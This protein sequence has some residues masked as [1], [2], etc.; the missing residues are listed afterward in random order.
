MVE[1]EVGR[2]SSIS[3]ALWLP[4]TTSSAT[5]PTTPSRVRNSLAD[6]VGTGYEVEWHRFFVEEKARYNTWKE[7]RKEW[8]W[9]FL[10]NAIKEDKVRWPEGMG[11]TNGSVGSKECEQKKFACVLL[12]QKDFLTNLQRMLRYSFVVTSFQ[13]LLSDL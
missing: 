13:A 5:I 3:L 4:R 12:M 7:K 6:P 11:Y 1:A 2:K 8:E 10:Q 9:E